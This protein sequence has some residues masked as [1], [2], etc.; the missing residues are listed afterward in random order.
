MGLFISKCPA[1]GTPIGWFLEAPEDYVCS[2][3]RP[4]SSE[5][6]KES[7]IKE[8]ALSISENTKIWI[9]RSNITQ[10]E[11]ERCC[12]VVDEYKRK[13]ELGEIPWSSLTRLCSTVNHEVIYKEATYITAIEDYIKRGESA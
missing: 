8:Y 2:C 11:I 13:A 3:G 12:L 9:G 1:C 7:Y 4:F 6:I 10:S 5:E